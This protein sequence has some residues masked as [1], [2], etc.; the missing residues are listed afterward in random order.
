MKQFM[1]IYRSATGQPDLSPQQMQQNM[2]AWIGWIQG[3]VADGWMVSGGDALQYD[4]GRVVRDSGTM[5]GPFIESKEIVGG[6]SLVQAADLDAA[7]KLTAG[8]PALSNGG[9]VEVR[10]L[11]MVNTD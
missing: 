11:M 1:F 7:Q 3:G 5:D 6:Y 10:E 9:S 2:Q 8:C 4:N